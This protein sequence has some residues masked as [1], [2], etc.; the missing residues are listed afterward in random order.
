MGR[1][2]ADEN[3][4]AIDDPGYIAVAGE[5]RPVAGAKDLAETLAGSPEVTEC[6]SK[7]GSAYTYGEAL[8][9][10]CAI[11]ESSWAS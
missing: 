1:D 7:L 5:R 4:L 8:G 6:V 11:S 10:E 9:A 2:R 3:G